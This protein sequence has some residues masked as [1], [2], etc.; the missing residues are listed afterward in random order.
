L[1]TSRRKWATFSS[2]ASLSPPTTPILRVPAGAR[3][4]SRAE[5]VSKGAAQAASLRCPTGAC[6]GAG[7]CAEGGGAGG[8]GGP[9]QA[10][11]A[12]AHVAAT[13]ASFTSGRIPRCALNVRR[14]RAAES[15]ADGGPEREEMHEEE[16]RHAE[17]R[18]EG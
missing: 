13:L 12:A 8:A 17:Q 10:A 9:L 15:R 4:F 11:S 6:A 5:G 1:P 14:K 16:D 7:G 2:A 18:D 3:T